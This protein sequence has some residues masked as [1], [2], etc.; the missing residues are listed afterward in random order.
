MRFSSPSVDSFAEPMNGF[1]AL[2]GVNDPLPPQE[3]P[4]SE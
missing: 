3:N 1:A 2:L 4:H